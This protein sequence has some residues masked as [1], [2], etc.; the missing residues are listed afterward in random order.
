MIKENNSLV[1]STERYLCNSSKKQAKALATGMS[2]LCD[3][4]ILRDNDQCLYNLNGSTTS[5]EPV[6]KGDRLP[7]DIGNECI[8]KFNPFVSICVPSST[9][10]TLLTQHESNTVGMSRSQLIPM[11]NI[12]CD[13]MHGNN[14][15]IDSVSSATTDV[16]N[17]LKSDPQNT[18]KRIRISNLN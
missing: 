12:N 2:G 14:S 6:S 13:H 16:N 10:I 11:N 18:L 7:A 4:H 3:R 15:K 9:V 8:S 1:N 5:P 17:S